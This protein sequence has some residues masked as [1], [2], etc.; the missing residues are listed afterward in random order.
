MVRLEK[1]TDYGLVILSCIA[2]SP[3]GTLRTARD[4][5][6]ESGLPQ[7]TVSRLLQDLLKGGLLESKRGIRGGYQLAKAPRDIS[8]AS[9]IV[10][11]EGPIRLT[12]CSSETTGACHLESHCT[13]K[14]NQ[15]VINAAV[16]G[17]LEQL[18]LADL[19]QPLQLLTI[20]DAD[21]KARTTISPAASGSI[22]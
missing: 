22:Q 13:I 19:M 3:R 12:V 8:I 2:R 15:R 10:A 1:F 14:T 7:P 18:S 11:L 16:R 21:G 6:S 9:V 4:L 17:V 5:A 20:Q